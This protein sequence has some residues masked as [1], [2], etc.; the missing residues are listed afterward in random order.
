MVDALWTQGT[1]ATFSASEDRRL[2]SAVL[3]PGVSSGLVI[4]QATGRQVSVSAGVA[5]VPD[6]SGGSYV[7]YVTTST[8]LTITASS[9]QNIY[10]VVDDPGAG[11]TT[12]VAGAA[13]SDP[14][15]LIGA[16]TA[17]ASVITA[18]NNNRSV[19]VPPSMAAGGP[20][21]PLLNSGGTN[22]ST[23]QLGRVVI[24]GILSAGGVDTS[25]NAPAGIRLGGAS[26]LG[27]CYARI[28]MDVAGQNIANTTWTT[29]N[30]GAAVYNYS[31]YG[32]AP[33]VDSSNKFKCPV[34]GVYA[35]SGNVGFDNPAGANVG[36]R[37][38]GVVRR[39][40]AG[41]IVWLRFNTIEATTVNTVG[42][43]AFI[44]CGA[45]DTLELQV[46][47]N[48]GATLGIN[49]GAYASGTKTFATFGL[50]I[51]F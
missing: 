33:Y 41:A 26:P 29:V 22:S 13:P 51:P 39:N 16:A 18:V 20:Q 25:V 45:G 47:H 15:L 34:A 9:T 14:N 17:D 43:D 31:I 23:Y 12:V 27:R 50:M 37:R 7:A 46:Y 24:P 19:A 6:G 44:D 38:I 1:G 10:I 40:A 42:V 5:I 35:A 30:L 11:G 32:S 36:Y 4:T 48:Q 49:P 21:Q 8:T 3:T 28:D 2:V